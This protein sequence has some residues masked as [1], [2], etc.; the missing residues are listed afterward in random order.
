M[1]I[2][3]KALM[4]IEDELQMSDTYNIDEDVLK[5]A[6][7]LILKDIKQPIHFNNVGYNE[8]LKCEF[9]VEADDYYCSNC[10]QRIYLERN[11]VDV[12]Y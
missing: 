4:Q 7:T 2:Q 10:G 6:I 8:C 9:S 5:Y 1:R 12:N 11:D 3:A